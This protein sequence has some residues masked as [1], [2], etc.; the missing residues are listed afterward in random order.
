[1]IKNK[2][3]IINSLFFNQG[4]YYIQLN[5]HDYFDLLNNDNIDFK[6]K[7]YLDDISDNIDIK[8]YNLNFI[9]IGDYFKE[10][11]IESNCRFNMVIK[12]PDIQYCEKLKIKVYDNILINKLSNNLKILDIEAS[13]IIFKNEIPNSI[14]TLI[15]EPNNKFFDLPNI[16]KIINL[17]YFSLKDKLSTGE[18]ENKKLILPDNLLEC[19]I[20]SKLLSNID[21]IVLG[22][23]LI[24]FE[25]VS[26]NKSLKN[27][28]FKYS[29][30]LENLKI[31]NTSLE[32]IDNLPNSLKN[33]NLSYNHLKEIKGKLPENLNKL[34]CK[35]NQLITLPELPNKLKYLNMCNNNF[36][37]I[38]LLPNNIKLF[39]KG[40]VDFIEMDLEEN[41]SI[42]RYS[43]IEIKIGERSINNKMDYDNYKK[44]YINYKLNSIK[45]AK[46]VK[47]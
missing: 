15:L 40:Y 16:N 26:K 3:I 42:S 23:N 25:Y 47:Y 35:N 10:I 33:I 9:K 38:P 11:E 20:N 24:K 19:K 41:N 7:L 37:N 22:G 29:L 12:L 13:N 27:I 17:K 32:Y 39:F 4:F 8:T 6:L 46:S 28:N 14:E 43:N 34:L 18:Y 5:E 1:M 21:K 2:E 31:N 44:E 45:S 30:N 36:N